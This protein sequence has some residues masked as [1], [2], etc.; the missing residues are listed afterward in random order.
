MTRLRR[1]LGPLPLPT[2]AAVV[3]SVVVAVLTR[4]WLALVWV[5]AALG[6]LIAAFSWKDIALQWQAEA[7]RGRLD[8][9][10]CGGIMDPTDSPLEGMSAF[11]CRACHRIEA[12]R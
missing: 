2:L 1:Y 4:N 6:W 3:V 7:Q 12:R 9:C 11:R 8:P 10:T 5:G